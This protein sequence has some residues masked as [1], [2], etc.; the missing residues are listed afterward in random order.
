MPEALGRRGLLIGSAVAAATPA[1]A[2]SGD[3][4]TTARAFASAFYQAYYV[5]LHGRARPRS[6]GEFALGRKAVAPPLA[7]LLQADQRRKPEDA[8]LDFDWLSN[9]QDVPK[10]FEIED[11]RID[12]GRAIVTVATN[13]GQNQRRH[14]ML[15]ERAGETWQIADMLYADDNSKET[16]LSALLR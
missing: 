7:A 4:R 10:G 2:Q 5:N 6:P 12:N 16:A 8:K 3:D 11:V 13:W 15:L 14:K 1:W 9:A